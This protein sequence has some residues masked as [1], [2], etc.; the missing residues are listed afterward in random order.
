MENVQKYFAII[1]DLSKSEGLKQ[2]ENWLKSNINII[3][4]Y[5]K[6]NNTLLET[7]ALKS[8]SYTLDDFCSE[9]PA[10]S[11]STLLFHILLTINLQIDLNSSNKDELICLSQQNLFADLVMKASK[12]GICPN[13]IP[14]MQEHQLF[15]MDLMQT[16]FHLNRLLICLRFLKEI[17]KVNF[18]LGGSK[19]DQVKLES[20]AAAVSILNC[21]SCQNADYAKDFL[22]YLYDQ[23][24]KVNYF[25]NLLILKSIPKLTENVHKILHEDLLAKLQSPMGFKV[26]LEAIIPTANIKAPNWKCFEVISNIVSHKGHPEEFYFNLIDQIF[27]FLQSASENKLQHVY[28][29]AG[30]LSLRKLYLLNIKTKENVLAKIDAVFKKLYDPEDIIAGLIIFENGEFENLLKFLNFLFCGSSFQSMPTDILIPYLP[31]LIQC[32]DQIPNNFKQGKLIKNLVVQCLMNREKN[33]LKTFLKSLVFEEFEDN[34]KR[35]HQR[36][37]INIVPNSELVNLQICS[38][39]MNNRNQIFISLS[40]ILKLSNN[41]ILIYNSF[42]SALRLFDEEHIFKETNDSSTLLENEEEL[43]IFVEKKYRTKFAVVSF[44]TDLVE[45]KPLHSQF[46]ENPIE[47]LDFIK[48]SLRKSLESNYFPEEKLSILLAILQEVIENME[49]LSRFHHFVP[50]IQRL[51]TH[52]SDNLKFQLGHILSILEGTSANNN[53]KPKYCGKSDYEIARNLMEENQPYLKVYGITLMIKLINQK[54][55]ETVNHKH[56]ILAMAINVIK[57]EESYV[58]LNC[59]KLFVTL[60]NVLEADV[61]N[62]LSDEYLS[63]NNENDYR[64]KIGEAI[65]KVTEDLGPLSYKYKNVLINCFLDG[66]RHPV[67]EFRMSSVSNLAT[68]CKLLT[69]QVHNFFQELLQL[70]ESILQTDKYLP[71]R[72]ASILVLVQLLSGMDNLSDFQEYLL[73]IYRILKF[74]AANES[75]PPMQI[76]ANNGLKI[77]AEKCKKLFLAEQSL[78]KEIKIFGIKDEAKTKKIDFIKI[79]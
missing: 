78:Q 9:D 57:E 71:V 6:L 67:D 38:S 47:I 79:N 20:M 26:L 56:N 46:N 49:D 76:H 42:I 73:P 24:C 52:S 21:N 62:V 51:L 7:R 30:V 68:I 27:N 14:E 53:G 23:S 65:L 29:P 32:Y 15:K 69:Y 17:Y 3:E 66:S 35:L 63:D 44:L 43:N 25:K 61:L 59:V 74:I 18:L 39:D 34:Y 72:R 4:K 8:I 60:I 45:F 22:K 64:L 28:L 75:D 16:K 2:D 5:I 37:I 48:S 58:F 1:E 41:N 40:Q 11:Y 36:I 10:W 77:L 31:L 54:D 50:I 19:L 33:E 13:I 12:Y 70:I 55:L